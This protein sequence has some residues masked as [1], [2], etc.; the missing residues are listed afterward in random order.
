MFLLQV[1]LVH[2]TVPVSCSLNSGVLFPKMHLITWHSN[3]PLPSD[4]MALP[5][6]CRVEGGAGGQETELL[7]C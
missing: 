3:S 6:A 1:A 2:V 5:M 7:G 4:P